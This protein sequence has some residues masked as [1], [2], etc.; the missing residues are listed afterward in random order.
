MSYA[1]VIKCDVCGKI[2]G[3]SNKWL[4]FSESDSHLLIGKDEP[5]DACSDTCIQKVVARV[6]E[7]LRNCN[8]E[9]VE[10]ISR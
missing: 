9:F 4:A 5:L 3:E 7:R 2:K 6:V 1:T 10:S 8:A